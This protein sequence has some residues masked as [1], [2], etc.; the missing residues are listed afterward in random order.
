MKSPSDTGEDSHLVQ[1]LVRLLR[2]LVRFLLAR[3]FTYI[4]LIQLLRPLYIELAEEAHHPKQKPLTDSRVSLLTGIARRYVKDLR[5]SPPAR[6][7][8]MLKASPNTRLVAEWV[9]ADRYTDGHGAPL[10]LSRYP[11]DD[12]APSFDELA[13]RVST[14]VHS[15]T[16]LDDLQ[17]KGL[18]RVHP[19]HRVELLSHA[20]RPDRHI[21]DMLD[22]FGMHLHDHL[23]AATHNLA[24]GKEPFFER[25]AFQDNLTPESVEKLKQFSDEQAMKMLKNVYA[26]AA[27]LAEADARKFGNNQRF[28]IGT[29]V[30]AETDDDSDTTQP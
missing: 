29:Y 15:R 3:G 19:D 5:R 1:A 9:T 20:Y 8:A 16:L 4:R 12:G 24:Q 22:Y 2:P 11:S 28:R 27:K 13:A 25:S 10:L 26:R 18:V 7:P 17:S 14:D 21:N 30:Y 6:D 23:A